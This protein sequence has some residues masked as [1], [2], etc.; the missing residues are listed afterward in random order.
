[1]NDCKKPCG[2]ARLDNH[3]AKLLRPCTS[4]HCTSLF[5]R[6]GGD[7]KCRI[8]TEDHVRVILDC[9][10]IHLE[11]GFALCPYPHLESAG[12]GWGMFTVTFVTPPVITSS[13]S[14][15]VTILFL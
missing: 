1:M 2:T 6:P 13:P 15:A 11:R 5:Q 8:G 12:G 9:N 14:P 10:R 7:L 4:R 3:G